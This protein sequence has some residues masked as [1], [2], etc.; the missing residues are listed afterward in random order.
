PGFSECYRIH[1]YLL[2]DISPFLAEVELEKAI[3]IAPRS[4]ISR[5]A[6]SQFLINEE[7]IDRANEQ[8]SEALKI[9]PNDIALQTCK[10]WVLTLNGEY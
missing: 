8:I 9:D 2:K 5:Y 10:A 3:D 6:Y 7:E 4:V 1:S